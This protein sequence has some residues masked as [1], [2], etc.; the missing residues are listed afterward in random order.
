MDDVSDS[1]SVA[2]QLYGRDRDVDLHFTR[3]RGVLDIPS[4]V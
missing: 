3:L 4:L 2:A 1:N